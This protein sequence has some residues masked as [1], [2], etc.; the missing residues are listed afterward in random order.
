[1]SPLTVDT[2]RV[3]Q[4][5]VGPTAAGAQI[6]RPAEFI[7]EA[8][9]LAGSG[10]GTMLV[11]MVRQAACLL[12]ARRHAGLHC[13]A[14]ALMPSSCMVR[15]RVEIMGAPKCRNVGESQSVL[16][17]IDPIISTRV[18]INNHG[19]GGRSGP[20]VQVVTALSIGVYDGWLSL[21]P[22]ILAKDL[23]LGR[24]PGINSNDSSVPH[25]AGGGGG[26]GAT[27]ASSA[28]GY[29][30]SEYAAQEAEMEG[31]EAGSASHGGG[32]G[33]GA[34]G[35]IGGGGWSATTAGLCGTVQLMAGILGQFAFGQVADRCF[36]R[37]SKLLL[38]L[39][40]AAATLFFG[41]TSTMFNDPYVSPSPCRYIYPETGAVSTVAGT[42]SARFHAP[43][44]TLYVGAA[45]QER[46]TMRRRSLGIRGRCPWT[47]A[48]RSLSRSRSPVRAAR[49]SS[50]CSTSS[51][52]SSPVRLHELLFHDKNQSSD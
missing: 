8:A 38:C 46:L 7:A 30:H 1:M 42:S 31:P 40:A 14:A 19:W 12:P 17:M 34:H 9:R 11:L 47:G 29:W 4:V 18:R 22:Q 6:K 25:L 26:G 23:P 37:R 50:R 48:G 44:P 45:M 32:A 5:Q 33:G 20:H 35:V 51:P 13:S 39:L 2:A 15:V 24:Q 10:G 52:R 43:R 16:N 27:A 49:G 28:Y 3:I 36:R 41:L 21:L